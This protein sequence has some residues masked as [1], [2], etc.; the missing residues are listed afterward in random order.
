M[1][2]SN[3]ITGF[4][5]ANTR[6]LGVLRCIVALQCSANVGVDGVGWEISYKCI[7]IIVFVVSWL[8]KGSLGADSDAVLLFLGLLVVHEGVAL[9]LLASCL[10]PR[11]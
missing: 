9:P 6:Y 7:S 2:E 3:K 8:D 11:S 10:L 1:S 5:G 4:G